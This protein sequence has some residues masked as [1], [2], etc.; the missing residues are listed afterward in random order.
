MLSAL[1]SRAKPSAVARAVASVPSY[2]GQRHGD[3]AVEPA[4]HLGRRRAERR[5][6]TVTGGRAGGPARHPAH[7]LG[8]TGAG[9]GGVADGHVAL[10]AVAVGAGAASELRAIAMPDKR[11]YRA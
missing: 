5:A 3:A 10:L 1:A 7:R 4:A 6:A 8:A 9:V 2:G 11:L